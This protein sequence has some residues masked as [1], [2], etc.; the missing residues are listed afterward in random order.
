MHYVCGQ[1]FSRRASSQITIDFRIGT[2]HKEREINVEVIKSNFLLV[3]F[4]LMLVF[5]VYHSRNNT[6]YIFYNIR[7]DHQEYR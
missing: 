5:S 6:T 3:K 1:K 4:Y 2:E 7:T